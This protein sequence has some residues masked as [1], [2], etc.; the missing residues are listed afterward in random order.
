[1]CLHG[2]SIPEEASV[3]L[4]KHGSR[5]QLKADVVLG[6]WVF[7]PQIPEWIQPGGYE[8]SLE[9]GR[10]K[11]IGVPLRISLVDPKGPGGPQVEVVRA[12]EPKARPYTIAF[13]GNPA[14]ICDGGRVMPDPMLGKPSEF[15]SAV[16]YCLNS[17]FMLPETLLRTKNFVR[18]VRIVVIF[19]RFLED[20]R[21]H[22]L[23]IEHPKHAVGEPDR[24][25]TDRFV[26]ACGEIPDVTFVVHGW[27]PCRYASA[28][29]SID[30]ATSSSTEF[31]F[32]G[33]L[34]EHGHFPS[35]AG[36]IAIPHFADRAHPV[37][38]H[39]FCHAASDSTNGAIIDLYVDETISKLVINKKHRLR[40]TDPVPDHFTYYNG[41]EF[42]SDRYGPGAGYPDRW[43]S[44]HPD[45]Q[46]RTAHNLMA[47]YRLSASGARN[48]RLD[49]LTRR[50]L[51]DRLRAKLGR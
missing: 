35:V 25:A 50:F 38:L 9:W 10:S 23:L 29:A 21:K 24:D 19:P 11:R 33:R 16:G 13:V 47:D 36:S 42:S 8:V 7:I 43:R 1:M 46:T 39:E 41:T 34:R 48:V 26:K 17:L 45:P 30:D 4:R 6:D 14:V 2:H 51:R 49:P 15:Y 31:T 27:K 12:G 3:W 5:V 20:P 37:P 32:D 44:Y 28:R 18:N 22:P 40:S